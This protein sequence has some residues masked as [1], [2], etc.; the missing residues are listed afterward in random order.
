MVLVNV[1]TSCSDT[2]T[3]SVADPKSETCGQPTLRRFAPPQ[4]SMTRPGKAETATR[5]VAGLD[6]P[7]L[8]V[9]HQLLAYRTARP[10]GRPEAGRSQPSRKQT[11]PI[12][13][14]GE[15]C[16]QCKRQAGNYQLPARSNCFPS[17]RSTMAG[18]LPVQFEG[19]SRCKQAETEVRIRLN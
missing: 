13:G 8:S 19:S 10:D 7:R 18:R 1:Y 6:S 11:D 2:S 3:S 5:T 16:S 15:V 12:T 14:T 17:L 9:T 4:Q